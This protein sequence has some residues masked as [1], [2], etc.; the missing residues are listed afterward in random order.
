M[1]LDVGLANDKHHIDGVGV[2]LWRC[3]HLCRQLTD[4]FH[5]LVGEPDIHQSHQ[6]LRHRVMWMAL[7]VKP[8]VHLVQFLT[9]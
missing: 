3:L 9:P 4:A 5:L 7:M 2:G 1:I 8:L 6:Q